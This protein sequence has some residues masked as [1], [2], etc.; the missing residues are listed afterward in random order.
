MKLFT[1]LSV[2]AL[3]IALTSCG[4]GSS[5][6]P[7]DSSTS[8]T[9]KWSGTLDN[10]RPITINIAMTQ[11][12]QAGD[13]TGVF[14]AVEV[15][16]SASVSGNVQAGTLV[17][18]DSSGKITCN[19]TFTNYNRYNASCVLTSNGASQFAKMSIQKL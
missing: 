1:S 8:V 9:G 18:V 5:T 14:T 17:G 12:N 3:G 11:N 4:G 10:N 15:A 13:F 7:V 6:T 2:L 19:G 16:G